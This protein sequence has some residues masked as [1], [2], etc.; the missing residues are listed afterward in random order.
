MSAS[1]TL[2]ETFDTDADS[3]Q[4]AH[5]LEAFAVQRRIVEQGI[6]DGISLAERATRLHQAEAALPVEALEDMQHLHAIAALLDDK[7]IEMLDVAQRRAPATLSETR[8]P[9]KLQPDPAWDVLRMPICREERRWLFVGGMQEILHH[10]RDSGRVLVME[11]REKLL[12]QLSS[13]ITHLLATLDQLDSH[14]VVALGLSDAERGQI[15]QFRAQARDVN[16]LY[17]TALGGELGI[18]S[19]LENSFNRYRVQFLATTAQLCLRLYG[20]VSIPH[21]RELWLL[22]SMYPLLPPEVD[23]AS[24]LAS[25]PDAERQRFQRSIDGALRR[26]CQQAERDALP[27]WPI[28]QVYRYNPRFGRK[29]VTQRE[30][31]AD[32]GLASMS[33]PSDNHGISTIPGL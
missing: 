16:A 6:C 11:E 30:A 15:A 19:L 26:L 14:L 21:L 2:V 22:K 9:P 27:I 20:N 25:L 28:L 5:W 18:H 31:I 23:P 24:L 17:A 4:R 33:P 8:L 32:T 7:L 13:R 1:C 10:Y 29:S 12:N 3:A